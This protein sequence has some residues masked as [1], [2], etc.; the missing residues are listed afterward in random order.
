MGGLWVP[1][2]VSLRFF[3]SPQ[4]PT[5]PEI[6]PDRSRS[7][8][9]ASQIAPTLSLLLLYVETAHFQPVR[10]QA[11]IDGFGRFYGSILFPYY[12]S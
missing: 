9:I 2:A 7:P 6:D 5:S 4:G 8:Q 11:Q 10:H 3:G 1:L 12:F